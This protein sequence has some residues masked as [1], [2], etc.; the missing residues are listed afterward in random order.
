MIK[1]II[2]SPMIKR[3]ILGTMMAGAVTAGAIANPNQ[4]ENLNQIQYTEV[5]SPSAAEGS[6]VLAFASNPVVNTTVRNRA[7]DN[8]IIALAE[9]AQERKENQDYL[10]N[11]YAKYGTF[12][13]TVDIQLLLNDITLEQAITKFQKN[14][15]AKLWE[16]Q[17]T[18]D[19]YNSLP[20]K[21]KNNILA[22]LGKLSEGSNSKLDLNK[23][24]NDMS[25]ASKN[26]RDYLGN[27]FAKSRRRAYA[28]ILSTQALNQ[29][30]KPNFETTS[31]LVD[32]YANEALS[33]QTE[34]NTYAAKVRNF[35][36]AQG[37]SKTIEQ[38]ANLISYK[39][40][41]IDSMLIQKY[42]NSV[43]FFKNNKEFNKFFEQEFMSKEP[44][45]L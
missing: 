43:E 7:L 8:K 6:K 34:R 26:F 20:A 25:D 19:D 21:D 12:G 45:K 3:T 42:I 22:V 4:T 44:K 14:A 9:N 39:L 37:G 27:D 24:V 5:A 13:A 10:N 38:K 29:N 41:L 1:P 30:G 17:A 28:D 33:T 32:K 16:M 18:E 40:F 36:T 2:S 11:T 15:S 31:T 23:M 35:N